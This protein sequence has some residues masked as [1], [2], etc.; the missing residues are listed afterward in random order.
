MPKKM[1]HKIY[2]LAN[3]GHD[4]EVWSS[5]PTHKGSILELYKLINDNLS[6]IPWKDLEKRHWIEG[7]R[8][9]SSLASLASSFFDESTGRAL[10]RKSKN[11]TDIILSFWLSRI[12]T[13]AK[14]NFINNPKIK[15]QKDSFNK[16]MLINVAKKSSDIQ[17]LKKLPEYLSHFGILLVYERGLP[18]MKTDGVVMKL[19]NGIPVI[20]MSLRYNRL[21]NFWFTLLHELAHV[22]L[23]YDL[24]ESPIVENLDAVQVDSLEVAANRLAQN[25][26]VP[27]SIWNRC[28]PRYEQDEKSII[29]FAR[30]QGIHPAIVAGMLQKETNR[31]DRYRKIVDSVNVSDLI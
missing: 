4:F 15:F 22:V 2:D 11:V 24:I 30:Q 7:K 16:D 21:D 31:Y 18:K 1:K 8:G 6:E 26:F 10:F 5:Q 20:G 27:R 17:V 23:H 25:S 3:E 9:V 29:K 14:I 13:Q 28:S 12:D 19:Q